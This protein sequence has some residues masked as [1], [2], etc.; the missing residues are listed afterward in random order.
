MDDLA[1]FRREM[2]ELKSAFA[3][4]RQQ[5]SKLQ[6][7]FDDCTQTIQENLEQGSRLMSAHMRDMEEFRNSR[8]KRLARQADSERD[9]KV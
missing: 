5:F 6:T 4:F 2:A 8:Q 9:A 7:E 3:K 1:K